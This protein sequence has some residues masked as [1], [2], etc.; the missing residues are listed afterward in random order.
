MTN[1]INF[2]ETPDAPCGAYTPSAIKK[3]DTV[4]VKQGRHKGKRG[5]VM[6]RGANLGPHNSPTYSVM[7]DGIAVVMPD[8]DIEAPAPRIAA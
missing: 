7:I 8:E 5:M 2:P 4:L 3:G 6:D 1:I